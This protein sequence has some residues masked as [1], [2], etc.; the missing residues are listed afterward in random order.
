MGRSKRD[1]Q[2]DCIVNAMKRNL[3]HSGSFLHPPDKSKTCSSI[4]SFA[5]SKCLSVI[6]VSFSTRSVSLPSGFVDAESVALWAMWLSRGTVAVLSLRSTPYVSIVCREKHRS[7][8]SRDVQRCFQIVP[9]ILGFVLTRC[10]FGSLL[11]TRLRPL[12]HAPYVFV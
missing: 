9:R 7:G 6:F 3:V 8:S 1:A 5:G 12:D 2:L 4:L 11:E 10:F